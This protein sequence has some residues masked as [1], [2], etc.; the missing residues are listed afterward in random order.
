VTP[1]VALRAELRAG[2]GRLMI[3]GRLHLA[4]GAR[5]RGQKSS[6]VRKQRMF[7]VLG[8]RI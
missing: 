6:G 1:G 8:S 4:E 7:G 2:V 5:V 3:V